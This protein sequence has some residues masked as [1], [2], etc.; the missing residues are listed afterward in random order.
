MK[1]GGGQKKNREQAGNEF[2]SG[3]RTSIPGTTPGGR[4]GGREQLTQGWC[5]TEI[6]T[7]GEIQNC[8]QVGGEQLSQRKIF[9]TPQGKKPR[10]VWKKKGRSGKLTVSKK[11]AEEVTR[12]R[13]GLERT[14]EGKKKNK[15]RRIRRQKF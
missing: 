14:M 6:P 2:K 8:L 3:K 10:T 13:G 9:Q 12:T 5:G 1:G 11:N 7:K 15:R 4:G